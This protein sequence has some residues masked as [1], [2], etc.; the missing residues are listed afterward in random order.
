MYEYRWK[1]KH[2]S[3]WA[4][5]AWRTS[6]PSL[7]VPKGTI[8]VKSDDDWKKLVL[9]GKKKDVVVLT[10]ELSRFVVP[11]VK[12]LGKEKWLHTV[13][14]HL[15]SFNEVPVE[16]LPSTCRVS[17][18]H[19]VEDELDSWMNIFCNS[20][21][22]ALFWKIH[23]SKILYSGGPGENS[24]FQFTL[25]SGRTELGVGLLPS[26]FSSLELVVGDGP[27]EENRFLSALCR[28]W[29]VRL[30]QEVQLC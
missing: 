3:N 29:G 5:A 16:G 11:V 30:D 12:D 20:R 26:A 17:R 24:R 21:D 4:V 6:V 9:S 23:I 15:S 2:P 28:C 10:G 14:L 7:Q 22:V 18:E 27:L 1:I 8:L 25:P 13:P 19:P